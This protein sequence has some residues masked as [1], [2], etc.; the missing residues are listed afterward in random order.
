M[1]GHAHGQHARPPAALLDAL[2]AT[3]ADIASTIAAAIAPHVSHPPPVTDPQLTPLGRGI[4]HMLFTLAEAAKEAGPE[5]GGDDGK[6]VAEAA[7]AIV[8]GLD[9]LEARA[10][11]LECLV[12]RALALIDLASDRLH[13]YPYKDVPV[14]WRR[15]YGDASLLCGVYKLALLHTNYNICQIRT[16]GTAT[17]TSLDGSKVGGRS[18]ASMDWDD[19]DVVRTL[20]M[21]LIMSGAPGPSRREMVETLLEQTH[22]IC[23]ALMP[24]PTIENRPHNS[25]K[26]RLDDHDDDYGEALKVTATQQQLPPTLSGPFPKH[27]TPVI[28]HPLKTFEN[29]P[30]FTQFTASISSPFIIKNL[31]PHWPALTNRPWSSLPYLLSQTNDG[32]RLVPV[33][34]GKHYIDADWG[35]RIIP[36]SQFLTEHIINPSTAPNTASGT[37]YLAQHDLFSQIPA[38]R[39]DISIPDYCY[40]EDEDSED[41]SHEKS[42]VEYPLLNAWFGPAGTISPLHTDPYQN[43]LC[44]VVGRKY[45]RL[46]DPAKFSAHMH[47]RGVEDG[48][49]D[50][51][52][53]AGVEVDWVEQDKPPQQQPTQEPDDDHDEHVNFTTRRKMYEKFKEA[54]YLEGIL[55][56]GDGLYIPVGWWHY[57]RS[58]D[59]SFSVSFWWK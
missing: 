8:C 33:E 34:V 7:E 5:S 47:P 1:A 53:T 41:E 25:L 18:T 15:L 28:K 12:G 49:V 48:G 37:G 22:K 46:Y 57:I 54:G 13:A 29:P 6:E 42:T 16:A 2:R 56:P 35:Q 3:S 27:E 43:I 11:R 58:L 55:E 59:V 40:A 9:A 32:K 51:S 36:F 14:C 23:K 38:L 10:L 39:G 21:G 44:Q 50:M 4:L 31:N 17:R 52:N 19:V 24:S 26:R 20:D 45:V 30:S